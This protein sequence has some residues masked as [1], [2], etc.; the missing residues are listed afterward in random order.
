MQRIEYEFRPLDGAWPGERTRSRKRAT[1]SATFNKTLADLQRELAQLKASQ[2]VIQLDCEEREIRRDGLPR[3]D[4][5]VRGPGVVLAFNSKHGPLSY[6]CDTYERWPDNLRAI[7]LALAALRAVDRYGVTKRAEQYKGWAKL[8]APPDQQLNVL[9]AR[10]VITSIVMAA[11]RWD[12]RGQVEAAIREA[13]RMT[14]PDM[15]GGDAT[16]FKRVQN[17]RAVILGSN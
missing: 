12:D 5:R 7:S 13:E 11:V 6:P 9:E 15:A 14:H 10:G 16:L 1:F 17:A 3:A 4:A 8:P 2:V